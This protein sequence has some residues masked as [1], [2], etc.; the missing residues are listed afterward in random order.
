MYYILVLK[1]ILCIQPFFP[2][3]NY[4]WVEFLDAKKY[5]YV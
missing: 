1:T 3:A 4:E 2:F 5:G